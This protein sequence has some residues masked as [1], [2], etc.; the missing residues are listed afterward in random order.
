M[1]NTQQNDIEINHSD[2]FF[3]E[4]EQKVIEEYCLSARYEFGESDQENKP[5]TGMVH[6]IPE[7]EFIF[8]LFA[9]TIY[10]RAE[11]THNM[12]LYR[13]YI[14]C[15]APSEQANFHTDGEGYTFLYYPIMK[16]YD[17]DEGGETQFLLDGNIFGIRPISNRMSVFDG[18]IPHRATPLRN[19]HRFTIAIKYE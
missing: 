6:N 19:N 15:F 12:K 16:E 14:N 1:V 17:L 13:M 8:K 5:V 11:F 2:N 7:T 10:D 3:T 9:K 4:T 18:I